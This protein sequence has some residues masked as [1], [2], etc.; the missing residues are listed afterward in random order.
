M[1]GM[2]TELALWAMILAGTMLC[3][4]GFWVEVRHRRQL[5]RQ[6]SRRQHVFNPGRAKA[7]G[8]A[9]ETEPSLGVDLQE[10]SEPVARP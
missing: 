9:Q 8:G 1:D 10:V 7:A 3:L 2:S 4:L 5:E 6:E